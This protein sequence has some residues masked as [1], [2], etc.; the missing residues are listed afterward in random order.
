MSYRILLVDDEPLV[1][2]ALKRTLIRKSYDILSAGSAA[3]ALLLLDRE[4]VDVVVSDEMMPGMPGS[5]FLGE[6]SSRFPATIRIIL[7]GH[8]N[9]DTAL[10]AINKGHIYQ[11]LI[12][13]C[14]GAELDLTIKRALK[15]RDLCRK[16]I[17]LI[18]TVKHQRALLEDLENKHPGITKVDWDLGGTIDI[19]EAEYDLDALLVEMSTTLEQAELGFQV[20]GKS[21]KE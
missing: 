21:K 9:L 20:A 10:R 12:K 1:I 5:D 6:V 3:E 17:S 14:T 2:E 16:S 11:F 8:P 7:T 4:S 18:E 19:P 13:P 15:Y